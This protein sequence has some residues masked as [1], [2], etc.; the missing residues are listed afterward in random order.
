MKILKVPMICVEESFCLIDVFIKKLPLAGYLC[1]LCHSGYCEIEERVDDP[2]RKK[3][4]MVEIP[5]QWPDFFCLPQF[6]PFYSPSLP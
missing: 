6:F 1:L 3:V 4:L 2:A 5:F